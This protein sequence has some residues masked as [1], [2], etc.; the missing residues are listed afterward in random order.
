MVY[1]RLDLLDNTHQLDMIWGVYQVH[2]SSCRLDRFYIV[3]HQLFH[4]MFQQDKLHML[5]DRVVHLLFQLDTEPALRN[6]WDNNDQLD[7]YCI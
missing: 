3:L 4:C 2:H 1:R 5:F 6:S 7:K